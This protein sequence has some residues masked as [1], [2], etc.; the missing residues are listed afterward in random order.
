[1]TAKALGVGLSIDVKDPNFKDIGA[2]IDDARQ[3]GVN[4]VELPL[5]KLDIVVGAKILRDRLADLKERLNNRGVAYTLHGH[6]GINLMEDQ[7]VIGL[8]KD[9][10]KANLEIAQ[11]LGA[12]HL[13]IH[14]G[15]CR[16]QQGSAVE[17]AYDRQREILAALGAEAEAADVVVCV[18]N[19]FTYDFGRHTAL[20]SRLA[21]ELV[22]IDHPFIQA[23]FDFSHGYQHCG[24]VGVDFVTEAKA[25]TPFSKHLHLH[26]SFGRPKDFW[27]YSQTE[28]LAFGA[29]DLHLPIGW[30]SI[31]WD[32]IAAECSFPDGVVGDIELQYRYWSEARSTVETAKAFCARLGAA[33]LAQ[34]AE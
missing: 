26:D 13:I 9:V 5:H 10:L 33:E 3:L 8:H 24:Q 20:P 15:F 23:T 2:A 14:S 16:P 34:A 27:T 19:I 11:A 1:M 32:R 4:F 25:L 6:L 21:A 30:G 29:G 18:E 7:H 31:P 12:V 17:L 22:L 28:D